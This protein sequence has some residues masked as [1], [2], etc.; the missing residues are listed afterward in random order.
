MSYA[1]ELKNLENA[2]TYLEL[3]KRA[4]EKKINKSQ[5][6]GAIIAVEAQAIYFRCQVIKQ[7]QYH[8]QEAI[9]C[10]PAYM[11]V[12]DNGSSEEQI[13]QNLKRYITEQG[14]VRREIAAKKYYA[15]YYDTML[16]RDRFAV[17]EESNPLRLK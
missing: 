4:K 11:G 13:L 7:L 15:D 9:P 1:Y 5:F 2:E 14:V 3:E 12:V 6:V 17:Y 8:C 10:N 16:G